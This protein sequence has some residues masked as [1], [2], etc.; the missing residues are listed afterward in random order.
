MSLSLCLQAETLGVY[1]DKPLPAPAAASLREELRNLMKE[2]GIGVE[3]RQMKE[4]KAGESFE[5]LMVVQLKGNCAAM[6][7]GGA[8]RGGPLAS[9][10]VEGGR[11]LPYTEVFCDR[12]E[13]VLAAGWG[14]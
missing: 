7:G 11:I 9:T 14:S 13:Q 8:M 4:R 5:R 10:Q 3:L 2:T 6:E 12:L 1:L